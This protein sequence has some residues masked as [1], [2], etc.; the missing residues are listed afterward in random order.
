MAFGNKRLQVRGS[1]K[2]FGFLIIVIVLALFVHKPESSV[3]ISPL[4]IE[5][6]FGVP[7]VLAHHNPGGILPLVPNTAVIRNMWVMG[8]VTW[9]VDSRAATYPNFVTQLR[10]V[11]NAA[12]AKARIPN[13][14]VS[15]STNPDECNVQHTMPDKQFQDGV[16]GQ[17][18]YANWP[19]VVEYNWRL[20]YTDWR[21]TQ[22][23]EGTVCGHAMGLHEGYDDIKFVSH[24]LT[25]NRWAYP[26]NAPTVMDF[27]THLVI[28]G[29]VWEC[30]DSD[31]RLL[32]GWLLS[33]SVAQFGTGR[34]SDGNAYI[35]YCNGDKGRATRI[36]LLKQDFVYGYYFLEHIPLVGQGQCQGWLVSGNPG[37]C[38]YL[39]QEITGWKESWNEGELR[40]DRLVGCF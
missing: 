4:N 5:A 10:Q 27:G 2:R 17:I 35:F 16:A 38:Y 24:I 25:Y 29:G 15:F 7:E 8:E 36:A 32:R 33:P 37:D 1:M 9:C 23:H 28:P 26:W 39:N 21:T 12:T 11:N 18:K 40:N 3:S 19:V 30:Q 34:H 14:Q 31:V 20:G 6:P 22:G 13:R